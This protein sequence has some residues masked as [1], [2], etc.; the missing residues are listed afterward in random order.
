[1]KKIYGLFMLQRSSSAFSIDTRQITNQYIYSVYRCMLSQHSTH[2][3]THYIL[4]GGQVSTTI[5]YIHVQQI[6]MFS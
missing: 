2:Q 5:Q 6:Y 3:Y 4:N 1:M